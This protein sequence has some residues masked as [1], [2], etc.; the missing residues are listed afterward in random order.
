MNVTRK[1]LAD[2]KPSELNPNQHTERGLQVIEDSIQYNGAGRSGL[3]A[4]DGTFI[5]GHG[6]WEAMAR[7][8]IEEVLEVEIDGH[9]W[10]VVKRNDLAPDDPKAKALMIADNRAS[11]L[12]YAPDDELTAALLADI[13][14]Q[15]E[16]LLRGTGFSEGELSALLNSLPG[17][18]QPDPGPQVDRADELQQVWQVARGDLWAIGEHRLL[19]GDSTNAED[20]ARVMG[21]E[22]ADAVVTDPPYS[23][24]LSST[25][26]MG[27]KAGGWHDMMNNASWFTD[28]YKQYAQLIDAGVIWVFSNWRSL[29]I[30]M[31][32]GFDSG[33]GINSV[34][35]WYKDWI[36][37]GGQLGLRPTYELISLTVINNKGIP[38]RGVEDFY[39]AQWSSHKPHGHQAEKPVDLIQHILSISECKRPFDPFSGSGTIFAAAESLGVAA[40]G[41]EAEPKYCAV[42][43]QRLADMGLTPRRVG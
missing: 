40:S 42:T 6:T 21:G 41:I 32:A 43:L 30:L 4:K 37:P 20:V 18:A 28:R 24:G 2:Y 25:M 23:F 8:G 1:K 16:A 34:M 39:T 36:G 33:L 9:Q 35:V 3:V 14:A 12:D 13:V 7:A 29:P 10:V 19:C 31:R 26:K 11:E 17:A 22:K 27:S 5:A 38:S 15:D